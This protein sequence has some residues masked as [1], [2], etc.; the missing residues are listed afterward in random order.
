MTPIP[1]IAPAPL[2]NP[3]EMDA[4]LEPTGPDEAGLVRRVLAGETEAFDA[5]VR[6][7]SPRV[8]RFLHQFVRNRHDAEDLTQQAFL[9]AFAKLGSFDPRRPMINW[10]LTI[11]RRCALNHFRAAKSWES[12]SATDGEGR[13]P[14]EMTVA[15]DAD[16]E[17]RDLTGNLWE[18]ARDR[19]SAREYEALWLRFGED[20]SVKEAAQVMGLT[21]PHIKILVFRAKR[22][23]RKGVMKS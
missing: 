20:L 5:L 19:L 4:P 23:L 8:F 14:D 17:H 22:A 15:P 2:L 1:T 21:Q 6:A 12:L 9:R 7:H 13:V 10:L 16:L 3:E 18:R 11:A